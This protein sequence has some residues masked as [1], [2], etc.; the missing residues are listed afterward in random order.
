MRHT[1]ITGFQS[2][3][4][5]ASS[6]AFDKRAIAQFET[7][8]SQAE[9]NSMDA[10]ERNTMLA[11][12]SREI[13]EASQAVKPPSKAVTGLK[14][15]RQGKGYCKQINRLERLTVGQARLVLKAGH[16]ADHVLYRLAYNILREKQAERVLRQMA[17]GGQ[18]PR[19]KAN[20][21]KVKH[22]KQGQPKAYKH[23]T[24]PIGQALQERG[25][26][27]CFRAA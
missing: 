25:E 4:I 12:I 3:K 2:V 21:S 1:D 7:E 5:S 27:Y 9:R 13:T 6:I 20:C 8:F 17:R 24:A 22:W 10:D 23:S 26:L 18:G 14:R 15:P 11:D 16:K 19:L